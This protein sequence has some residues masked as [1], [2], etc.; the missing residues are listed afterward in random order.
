LLVLLKQ[1]VVVVVAHTTTRHQQGVQEAGVQQEP[2]PAVVLEHKESL[3]KAMLVG[4]VIL[5]RLQ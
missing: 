4:L 5:V 1:L 2:H 3:D